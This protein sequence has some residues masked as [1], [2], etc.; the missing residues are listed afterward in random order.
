M[1][2][3]RTLPQF[4]HAD[5]VRY[6]NY[7]EQDV[8]DPVFAYV[9]EKVQ[10]PD[11]GF[12]LEAMDAHGGWIA[13]AV[14][15]VRFASAVEGR[16]APAL[17]QPVTIKQMIAQPPPPA[18]TRK[19]VYCGLGWNIRP[20]D[21]D[22]SWFHTGSLPGTT[23]LLVRTHNGLAYAAL[24]NTRPKSDVKFKN[25]VEAALEKASEEVATWPTHDLAAELQAQPRDAGRGR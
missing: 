21:N 6:Y 16:A 4:R 10:W 24:F 15:L 5:E 13:S 11:G 8:A 14:D 25:E 18:N 1:R 19:E 17:L 9:K 2:L 7:D 22:A 12:N 23:T 3:G 20:R